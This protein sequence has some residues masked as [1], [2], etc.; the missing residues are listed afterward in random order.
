[1]SEVEVLYPRRGAP[2]VNV[3]CYSV[4]SKSHEFQAIFALAHSKINQ[5]DNVRND[6]NFLSKP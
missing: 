2:Y 1:M 4:G 5:I 3:K 6:L